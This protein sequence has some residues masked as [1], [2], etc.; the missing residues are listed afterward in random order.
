MEVHQDLLATVI[1]K[2]GIF[3]QFALTAPIAAVL[4]TLE[5]TID[6]SAVGKRLAWKIMLTFCV[7]LQSFAFSLIDLIPTRQSDVTSGQDQLDTAVTN[8]INLYEQI[9]IPSLLFP[10]IMPICIALWESVAL[11]IHNSHQAFPFYPSLSYSF[12]RPCSWK[13]LSLTCPIHEGHCVK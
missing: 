6:V 3:A 2:H 11:L 9:C 1:G 5:A 7:L 13:S 10:T 12:Y 4:E 8:T